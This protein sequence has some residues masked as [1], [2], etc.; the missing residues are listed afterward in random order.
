[1]TVKT[2]IDGYGMFGED[3]KSRE[4]GEA[5]LLFKLIHRTSISLIEVPNMSH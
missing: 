1:M 2:V 5:T 4:G 3:A